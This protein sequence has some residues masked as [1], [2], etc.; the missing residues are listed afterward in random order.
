M[1]SIQV[2]CQLVS[3]SR[4][5]VHAQ[6]RTENAVLDYAKAHAAE[7]VQATVAKPG[8]IDG[9]G[10]AL[11][12]SAAVKGIAAVFGTTPVIHVSEIAAA[13]INVCSQDITQE[14]LWASDL[15]EMGRR[16]LQKEDYLT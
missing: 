5:T 10:R 2:F 7:E 1:A 9:P 6:G 12:V 13:M 11:I 15:V 14:P 3:L 4:L 16:V 8:A